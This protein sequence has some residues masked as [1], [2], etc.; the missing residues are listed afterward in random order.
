MDFLGKGIP[1]D[2]VTI[3]ESS[4]VAW[5][6]CS[7]SRLCLGLGVGTIH[8]KCLPGNYSTEEKHPPN[9]KSNWLGVYQTLL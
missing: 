6:K 7:C 8:Q 3:T 2:H 9:N 4:R 1:L 5:L